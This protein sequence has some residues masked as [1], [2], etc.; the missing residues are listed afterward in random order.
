MKKRTEAEQLPL[1]SHDLAPLQLRD[2]V[3]VISEGW[4]GRVA[5]IWPGRDW[6][7]VFSWTWHGPIDAGLPI[8][9]REEL[10][11]IETERQAT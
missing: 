3:R 6:Y 8:Y 7:A 4:E 9:R 10:E 1:L 5:Q 11:L 2:Q